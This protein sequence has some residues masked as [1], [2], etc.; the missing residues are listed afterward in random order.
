MKIGPLHLALGGGFLLLLFGGRKKI[1]TVAASLVEKKAFAQRLWKAMDNLP[2]I[3]AVQKSIIIAQG[4]LETGWGKVGSAPK[5]HNYWNISAGSWTG[6]TVPGSDTACDAQGGN[7]KP[8]TQ[9]WRAY[10]SEREGVLGF[11]LFLQTQINP[12]TGQNRYLKAYRALLAG[13]VAT[14]VNELHA[15]GY[16]TANVD[17]YRA[18]VASLVNTVKAVV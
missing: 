9:R 8:I 18:S 17:G 13:D 4:A 7:C 6:P 10:S 12:K 1:T 14:Y 11:L 16:F 3:G 2:G 15:G 5:V